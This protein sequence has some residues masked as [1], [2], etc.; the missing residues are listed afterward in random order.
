MSAPP[1][2]ILIVDDEPPIRKLLRV[3]L[4]TQDYTAIEATN[5]KTAL[6]RMEDSAPDLVILDLGLPDIQGHELLRRW[7]DANNLVPVIILSSRTDE[8]GI[9]DALELGA[10]D[11]VTKPFGVNELLARIRV[12]LRHRLQQ[13][14]EKPVFQTGDLSIDLVR[15]IVKVGD[16]EIKL[17][18][19]EYDIL[20]VMAQHA[21]KVLT[22]NF[23]LKQVWGNA[24]DVQ[25]LRVY[26]RQ[27][28]QKIEPN[29]EQPRYIRTE[30]GVGYRLSEGN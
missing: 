1:V 2:R 10:D 11:Y 28:R 20:R 15:R 22:H 24:Y 30:T 27:L 7:R 18:P 14:G 9:V 13:Q 26:V 23:L 17:S 6:E 5:G 16:E 25:Y 3:G 12:A 29:P 21:G 8:A 19:K 4:T